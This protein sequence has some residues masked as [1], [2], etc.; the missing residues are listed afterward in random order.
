MSLREL[1]DPSLADALAYLDLLAEQK[2]EKLERAAVRWHG[3]LETETPLLTLAESQ[4][5]L[6]AL[7]SLATGERDAIKVLRRLLRRLL[8]WVRPTLVPG[9][10][11]FS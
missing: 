9:A 2:P 11:D 3:R 10:A 1:G 6:A 8:P 4:L 5:A 7:A